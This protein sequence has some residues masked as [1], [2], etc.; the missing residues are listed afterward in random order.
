LDGP[1]CQGI[2]AVVYNGK[3][4]YAI[5]AD[6]GPACKIGEGSMRLH[7]EL[8]NKACA[9]VGS[10]GICKTASNNGIAKD[11]MFF[12]FPHSAALISKGLTPANVGQRLNDKGSKLIQK[13]KD[14]SAPPK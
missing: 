10:S 1:A 4:E 6:T 13:L 7:D 14:G 9:D 8:G 12:V 2:A 5:V 11:V 3:T